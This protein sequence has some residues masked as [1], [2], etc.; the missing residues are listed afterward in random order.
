M[1][2][3]WGPFGSFSSSSG[4]HADWKSL[5]RADLERTSNVNSG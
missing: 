2:K 5:A 1:L 3:R 4:I